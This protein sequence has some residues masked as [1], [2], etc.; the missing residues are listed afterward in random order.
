MNNP[1]LAKSICTRHVPR[2]S[3]GEWRT[4]VLKAVIWDE[5]IQFCRFVLGDGPT[6][7]IPTGELRR[8][9][10]G[11]PDKPENKIYGPFTIDPATNTIDGQEIDMQTP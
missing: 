2:R 7:M 10:A 4:D 9:L 3:N 11:Q 5:Q 6:V 8:V 1:S